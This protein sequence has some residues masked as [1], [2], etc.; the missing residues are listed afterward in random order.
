VAFEGFLLTHLAWWERVMLI[1]A[2]VGLIF[3]GYEE[4]IAGTILFAIVGVIQYFKL[5]RQKARA[6]EVAA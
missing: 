3:P 5:K 2:S 4:S 6:Q 1:P